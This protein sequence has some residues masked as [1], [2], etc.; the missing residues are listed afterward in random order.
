MWF[1]AH[2]LD[3]A[4]EDARNEMER[5]ESRPE[6]PQTVAVGTLLARLSGHAREH[7]KACS[8]CQVFAEELLEVRV[9]LQFDQQRGQP[10]QP[11][12]IPQP[13][14]YFMAR[15]MTAIGDREL[16]QERQ[17]QT[18]AAVPRL[19]HRISVMASLTLLIAGS[20]LYE[21]PAPPSAVAAI[22]AEQNS[23]GLVD[24]SSSAI[25]DDFLLNS[26]GR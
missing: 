22:N 19:A 15:V 21:R 23:E 25:P 8:E 24:G 20:W 4:C 2:K 5:S 10:A 9:I 12:K 6:L 3:R 7:V 1:L 17:A 14:P 11:E 13:G 26:T 18:W 16:E